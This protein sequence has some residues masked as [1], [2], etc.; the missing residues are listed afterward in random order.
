MLPPPLLTAAGSLSD[1]H[2]CGAGVEE[3]PVHPQQ[4]LCL[5][6]P[7]AHPLWAEPSWQ[8]NAFRKSPGTSD[9]LKRKVLDTNV[10]QTTEISRSFSMFRYLLGSFIE[11]ILRLP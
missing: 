9:P 6:D 2:L 5:P 8:M 1:W 11:V 3:G 7:T 10:L 4:V